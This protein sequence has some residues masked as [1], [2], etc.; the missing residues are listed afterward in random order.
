MYPEKTIIQKDTQPPMFMAALFTIAG[1]GS[2]MFINRGMDK[3]DEVYIVPRSCLTLLQP[4]GLSPTSLLC[5]WV[6]KGE[7][8]EGM[9]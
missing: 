9:N 7:G 8:R 6:T 1:H 3:E 5:P 4:H 2:Q